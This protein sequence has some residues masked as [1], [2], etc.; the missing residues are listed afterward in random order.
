M[1]AAHF[2]QAG[3]ELRSASTLHCLIEGVHQLC[4]TMSI[5]IF[6]FKLIFLG[7][8]FLYNGVLVSAVQQSESGI[9]V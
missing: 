9:R 6:F 4:E 7:V 3:Q 8:W 5:L 2:T 1:H